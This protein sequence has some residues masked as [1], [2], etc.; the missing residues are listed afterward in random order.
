MEK[1][2]KKNKKKKTKKKKKTFNSRLSAKRKRR[3]SEIMFWSMEIIIV[4]T[5]LAECN[6]Q[7]SHACCSPPLG[8]LCRVFSTAQKGQRAGRWRKVSIK[9]PQA[10]LSPAQTLSDP[11]QIIYRLTMMDGRKCTAQINK[12]GAPISTRSDCCTLKWQV[13]AWKSERTLACVFLS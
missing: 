12:R 7:S 5:Q 10:Q 3:T 11:Y 8:A 9:T 13:M 1:K 6:S 4:V 2:K